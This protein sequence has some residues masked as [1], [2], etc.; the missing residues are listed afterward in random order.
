MGDQAM[1]AYPG[2]ARV[3]AIALLVGMMMPVVASAG[4]YTAKTTPFLKLYAATLLGDLGGDYKDMMHA[5]SDTESAFKL[6]R[7]L[8]GGEARTKIA[9]VLIRDQAVQKCVFDAKCK[10]TPTADAKENLDKIKA[11]AKEDARFAGFEGKLGT[12]EEWITA[13]QS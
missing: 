5:G 12:D 1:A 8:A 7:S 3:F 9:K 13:A 6:E 4:A 11:K 2:G 10:Y